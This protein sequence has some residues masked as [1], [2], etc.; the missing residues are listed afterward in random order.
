MRTVTTLLVQVKVHLFQSFS[1]KKQ[2][3]K[4]KKQNKSVLGS[5]AST[6]P[7]SGE[8]KVPTWL[9]VPSNR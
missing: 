5:T 8:T 7:S 4:N 1:P 6:T 3:T 2:K 9:R